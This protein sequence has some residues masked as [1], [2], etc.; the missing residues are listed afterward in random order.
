MIDRLF[1]LSLLITLGCCEASAHSYYAPAAS[2]VIKGVTYIAFGSIELENGD[3]YIQVEKE[4]KG[5]SEIER[6]KLLSPYRAF[7]STVILTLEKTLG[8]KATLLGKI[9]GADFFLSY[10]YASV[11]P[12]G[13][14]DDYLPYR[15][16][17]SIEEYIQSQLSSE[18]FED[19][20][21]VDESIAEGGKILEMTQELGN[22]SVIDSL[23]DVAEVI[24]KVTAPEPTIEEPAEV[25]VAEPSKEPVEKPSNWLLWLIGLFVVVG[26]IGWILRRE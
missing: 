22:E 9:D 2:E 1:F 8:G 26:V 14:N 20:P 17:D 5:S 16:H 24:K 13:V 6:L 12:H 23:P 4:Y 3:F 18:N 11:W 25:V 10:I 21:P 7:D 19:L 15:T